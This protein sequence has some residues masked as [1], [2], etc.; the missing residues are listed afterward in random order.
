MPT[1]E[2]EPNELRDKI[3][4]K[5]M[6]RI[7]LTSNSALIP[8]HIAAALDQYAEKLLAATVEWDQTNKRRVALIHKEIANQLSEAE[9]QEL[10]E[11]QALADFRIRLLTGGEGAAQ[12]L[13]RKLEGESP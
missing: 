7:D 3:V 11:L 13:L 5:C 6:V 2:L 1:P 12:N 9:T 10:Q 8:K 4:K